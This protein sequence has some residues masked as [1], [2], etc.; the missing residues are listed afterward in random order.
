MRASDKSK[1][2]VLDL[3]ETLIHSCHEPLG[4]QCDFKTG[5]YFTY[6]RNNLDYFL[7]RCS[8]F[9]KMA[10]W[11]SSSSEYAARIV[12]K[13]FPEKAELE[14]IFSSSRCTPRWDH[15]RS[16]QYVVKPIKKI[17]KR[18]F[19]RQDII[20]IDDDPRTFSGNYGNAI[21]VKKFLGQQN[22]DELVLLLK[23]LML[24]RDCSD[25]RRTDKRSWRQ[26]A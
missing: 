7:I 19:K 8:R 12:E 1:L 23:Y 20:I 15:F 10:V 4:R 17:Q 14:F 13:V 16:E 3:D 5:D 9:F 18:G 2:L 22:D 25:V 26:M 21:Q 11:T 6:K 24:L